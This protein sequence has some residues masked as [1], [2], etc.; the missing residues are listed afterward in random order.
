MFKKQ[1]IISLLLVF[2]L[3]FTAF[4]VGCNDKSNG[5]AS[6]TQNDTETTIDSSD[7]T[8][9]SDAA[10][11]D[12]SS[13]GTS[14]NSSKPDNDY[15]VSSIPMSSS[16]STYIDYLFS[17]PSMTAED[18]GLLDSNPDRGYRTEMV[19]YIEESVDADDDPRTAYVHQSEREIREDLEFVFNI[20]FKKNVTPDDKLFLA[21]IYITD[22]RDDPI[23][24]AEPVLRIFFEMCRER[25]VKSML[26]F[27]YN[28]DY[29]INYTL[30]QA[31]K[32]KLA[33]QCADEKTILRHVN[34]L[35]PYI[36]E[37]SDTIHT[38]SCGFVGFV[39]EWAEHYQYPPVS[40]TKIMKAIVEKLCVPNN[41]YFSIRMPS[42]KAMIE[43]DYKYLNYISYNND[44]MYGEQTNNGW[45]SAEYQIGKPNGMW[46]YVTKVAAYTPQDGEMYT[47]DVLINWNIRP[48]GW[49]IIL[50]CAHHR[51]TSMSN[52]HGYIEALSRDNIIQ[53][54][55]DTEKVTTTELQR[56]GIVYDL[57]WF[58]N[59][60]G[61]Y[62][63][64]NP[65]EF[66]KDHLGYRLSLNQGHIKG[67]IEKGS[68]VDFEITL[69]NYGFAAPYML[70]SGFA[71]LD[72]NYNVVYTVDAGEPSTWYSHAPDNSN[73]GTPLSHTVKA[74]MKLPEKSGKYYISFYLKNTMN[75]YARL[76]NKMSF[77]NGQNLLFTFMV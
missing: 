52:W 11:S 36:S 76:A 29:A 68:T 6:S 67:D 40:Y 34:E 70:T 3:V 77:K 66:L 45:N 58:L 48:T 42:Y 51:H 14:S 20:Y 30:S 18:D 44:A 15:G 73:T 7:D 59:E 32:D 38:I 2:S 60:S 56:K 72:E 55:I 12:S 9:S 27:C 74:K 4:A 33:S 41:L 31:N 46:E 71:V 19:L 22:F 26:R 35:A 64:R 75:D 37:Y 49:D 69:K 17:F 23:S 61:R 47:N 10:S 54:W 50:E 65:Y 24:K 16:Q 21:Y 13:P 1:R 63:N 39:G 8:L 43:S 62:V 28:N 5:S 53:R 57:S 25:K